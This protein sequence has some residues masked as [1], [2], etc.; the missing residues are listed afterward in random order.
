MKRVDISEWEEFRIGELF[1][2]V[3]GS[4]LTNKDKKAGDINYIGA[5]AFNNGITDHIGNN[6]HLHPAGTLTVAY[7]G[8]IGET[9]YQEAPFWA[10]DAVNILYPNFEITKHI[11]MFIAP[12]IKVAGKKYSYTNK[13]KIEDM[14]KD[15]IYLPA[16]KEGNEFKPDWEFINAYMDKIEK[17]VLNAVNQYNTL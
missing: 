10:S 16:I 2:I 6:E 7:D 9:F 14:K 4:R 15:P 1:N 11:A 17:G 8:S 13:W 5:T 12:L 3:K